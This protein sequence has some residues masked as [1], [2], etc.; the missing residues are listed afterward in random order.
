VVEWEWVDYNNFIMENDEMKKQAV[1]SS[2]LLV[3]LFMVSTAV[4]DPNE[5][6]TGVSVYNCS[7]YY[8][9]YVP[10]GCVNGNGLNVNGPDTHINTTGNNASWYDAFSGPMWITFDL[11]GEGVLKQMKIWNA[12]FAVGSPAYMWRYAKVLVSL[13]D[14]DFSDPNFY[15]DLGQIEIPQAPMTAT[16]AF[17]KAYGISHAGTIRYVKLVL[18]QKWVGGNTDG[19]L[20]EVQFRGDIIPDVPVLGSEITPVTMHSCSGAYGNNPPI[21]CLNGAG[22]NVTGVPDT[23]S[24]TIADGTQWFEN[25]TSSWIT[26]DLG[27]LGTL[28]QLKIWNIN[29]FPD[30]PL[31]YQWRYAQVLV[32]LTNPAFD[33]PA[34]YQDL[35]IIEIPLAPMTNTDPFGKVFQISH[36]GQI[37]YVKLI[38]VGS[39]GG[40]SAPAG[41]GLAEIK[42]YGTVEPIP[43]PLTLIGYWPLDGNA[44][45]ASGNGNDGT[46]LGAMNWVDGQKGQCAQFNGTDTG[47]DIANPANFEFD[48]EISMTFWVYQEPAQPSYAMVLNKMSN[49]FANIEGWMIFS[50]QDGWSNNGMNCYFKSTVGEY[51]VKTTPT[52][53]DG[54]HHVAVTVKGTVLTLYFDGFLYEGWG[55]NLPAPMKVATGYPLAFGHKSNPAGDLGSFWK[56]M[57]DEVRFYHGTLSLEDVKALYQQ[58][59]GILCVT[60]PIAEDINKDCHVDLGDFAQLAAHWLECYAYNNYGCE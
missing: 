3:T 2:L 18:N 25:A 20:A 37:R 1:L 32:S 14:P 27:G 26:A 50:G 29:M 44:N 22:L 46:V 30:I 42:F 24:C 43:V 35:G 56:G 47:I 16:D 51:G 12:N 19:G 60:E 59:G 40:P 38:C 17:G 39:W 45:D 8:G 34:E 9:P 57:L 28:S 36:T 54:W 55:Y 23:H 52:C 48:D 58:G 41:R 11:G 4:A 7:G 53:Q 31:F 49:S 6:L 21:S 33:N 10:M 15:Q 5:L 13:T